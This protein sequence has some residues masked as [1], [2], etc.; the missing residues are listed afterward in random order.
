MNLTEAESYSWYLTIYYSS[1]YFMK[2]LASNAVA[3]S[4]SAS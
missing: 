2:V 4:C 1:S 3:F